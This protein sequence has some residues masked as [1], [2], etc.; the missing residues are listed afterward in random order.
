MSPR[1]R[2]PNY[3]INYNTALPSIHSASENKVRQTFLMKSERQKD[4]LHIISS[5]ICYCTADTVERIQQYLID[6]SNFES[7]NKS[8][9]WALVLD[10][11]TLK[12][13]VSVS[14]PHT[15]RIPISCS[16]PITLVTQLH[17]TTQHT[18]QENVHLVGVLT[19]KRAVIIPSV[20]GRL[21]LIQWLIAC[22]L[23][24]YLLEISSQRSLAIFINCLIS[25][26]I[27]F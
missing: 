16:L 21:G 11:N 6:Y 15:P 7:G 26:L 2:T 14:H 27:C 17:S 12:H 13:N 10:E 20:Y 1:P 4:T 22:L 25:A 5:G 3:D 9:R 24:C 8:L 19:L 23:L 18:G